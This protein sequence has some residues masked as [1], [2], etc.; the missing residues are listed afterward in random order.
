MIEN[1]NNNIEEAIYLHTLH[2]L[3]QSTTIKDDDVNNDVINLKIIKAI[4]LNN[5][6]LFDVHRWSSYKEVNFAVDALYN[7]LKQVNGFGINSTVRKHHLKV[8]IL[9]LYVKW[10]TD[11]SMYSSFYRGD[12]YYQDIRGRYNKLFITKITKKV[13]V[14]LEQMGYLTSF[15]GCFSR[16]GKRSSYMSRMRATDKLINV[17]VK[18]YQIKSHMIELAP[19]TECI[20]M[21][22]YVEAKK[23]QVNIDYSDSD[24]PEISRWR[25]ELVAYNNLLRATYIDIPS[26]PQS[27]LVTSKNSKSFKSNQ[28]IQLSHH[29]KF[30]KRIFN[31]NNWENGGRFYG[32]WWQRIPSEWRPRIRIGNMPISEIDYKGL[33]IVILYAMEGI[34]YREDPYELDSFE[35]SAR[36]RELL[37][38]VLLCSINAEDPPSAIAAI[39]MEINFNPE[40]Y[41]W[42][43]E[44]DLDLENLINLFVSKHEVIKH[45]F[46]KSSGIRLQNLDSRMAE[47]V[48]NHF[49]E[50]KIPVLCIHDSFVISTDKAEELKAKMIESFQKVVTENG[51]PDS[52]D[53]RTTETSLGV[54]Q[55]AVILSDPNWRDTLHGFINE[56]NDYPKWH[57]NLTEF[58]SRKIIDYYC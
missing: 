17:I 37:K 52:S 1:R 19:D 21:R 24:Y 8:I 40:E 3:P 6:S 54:G 32:G 43:K 11:P 27:G 38:Q 55:W 9:D 50:Q 33:H 49:T 57:K 13:L 14:A 48:I 46:F 51:L 42:T 36:M 56:P 2:E 28:K 10:I 12:Y 44:L 31:N 30:I 41:S 58:K 23:K 29:E 5:S 20:V 7:E 53:P 34:N 15:K 22:N 16:D 26:F 47:L 35:V 45:Y 25:S 39:Q 4:E 18:D